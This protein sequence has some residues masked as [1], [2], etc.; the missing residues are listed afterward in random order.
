MKP[1]AHIYSD[2]HQTYAVRSPQYTDNYGVTRRKH[3]I[4]TLTEQGHKN[5]ASERN[6]DSILSRKKGDTKASKSH[7]VKA[8]EHNRKMMVLNLH[9]Y[10]H[11][12]KDDLDKIQKKKLY[13]RDFGT[14]R[15]PSDPTSFQGNH[16]KKVGQ[17]LV[18][19]DKYKKHLAKVEKMKGIGGD[20]DYNFS[21][22]PKP[23]NEATEEKLQSKYRHHEKQRHIAQ[24]KTK[25]KKK[26]SYHNKQAIA[27]LRELKS[28]RTSESKRLGEYDIDESRI[29]LVDTGQEADKPTFTY[30]HPKHDTMLV[31]HPQGREPYI[32]GRREGDHKELAVMYTKD[33]KNYRARN[34][35]E[36]NKR[37]DYNA[38]FHR[39]AAT[40]L[41]HHKNNA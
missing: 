4:D 33:A 21:T 36:T 30:K 15:I 18:F 38:S 20:K 26:Y 32:E 23:F 40:I 41:H 35:G 2:K 17:N 19:T 14:T 3:M 39:A 6:S 28:F 25:D 24:F 12:K 9:K 37:L 13:A 10:L 8:D 27:A 31:I 22:P 34:K 11:G 7:E 29:K 16:Y 5:S 1:P